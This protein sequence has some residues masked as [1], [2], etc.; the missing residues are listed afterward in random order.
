MSNHFIV[1]VFSPTW[2]LSILLT[3]M[4]ISTIILWS[5]EQTGS[6][7]KKL[8]QFTGCI[9]LFIAVFIHWYQGMN[10]EWNLQRSLPLNLCSLS[11]IL[12]GLVL[13]FPNQTGYEFLLYWGIPGAFHSF[14]T[15]E[16]TLGN[17]DWYFYDYYLSHG[18][19]L[20]SALYLSLILKF[21]PREHS[22]WR[23]WIWSQLLIIAVFF[24]DKALG[25]NYMYLVE[26]PAAKNPFIIGRWPEYLMVFE[27]VAGV[28]F[29]LVYLI[30][31][32]SNRGLKFQRYLTK[33]S[34]IV[35]ILCLAVLV[36]TKV[37]AQ[38]GVQNI[39]GVIKD[40]ETEQGLSYVFVGLFNQD[41][42]VKSSQT[43]EEGH[44]EFNEVAPGRYSINAYLLGYKPS[45]LQDVIVNSGK[46]TLVDLF[47]T[48]VPIHLDKVEIQ[49]STG[50]HAINDMTLSGAKLFSVEETNRYA[51]SR[52]DPARMATCFAGTQSTDDSRN[53]IVIRGNSPLGILWRIQDVDIPNP[54]HFAI[55][56]TTGGA[57]SILNNKMF[58]NSDFLMGAFP[59]EYGNCNAG[60]FD[61]KLRNGNNQNHEGTVQ[62]GFLG[63][64]IIC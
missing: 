48:E 37:L 5:R 56:G 62:F 45:Q 26:K 54:N 18:G 28:H 63:T 24:L 61:I 11:G 59:A 29:Y 1:N 16:F 15:P 44:F 34:R 39:R 17:R 31:R 64:G 52:G 9:L 6:A 13:L 58:R 51:G 50:Q 55:P 21:R 14:L 57:I 46:E 23:I 7:Q 10:G 36:N 33:A 4:I 32:K 42:V 2:W 43:D 35:F 19:I 27:V 12:S 38:N 8:S 47:M 3:I 22:W 40:L 30:F 41:K 53:D 25:A 60:V 49:A 20:L